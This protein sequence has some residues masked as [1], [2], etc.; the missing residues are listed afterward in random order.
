MELVVVTCPT[1]FEAEGMLINDFFDAGLDLLHIRKPD[2]EP[3]HFLRL[4]S[5]IKPEFY[6]RLAI[7]QHH[8]L[9]K[10]FGLQRLHFTERQRKAQ[11]L[12]HLHELAAAGYRLSSSVHQL[13]TFAGLEELSYVF[14]GPVFDSISKLGYE[15][16]LEEGFILPPHP[17]KVFAIGGAQADRFKEIN[18]M[19][20][21]GV[22]VLGSLWYQGIPPLR[23]LK[24][25]MDEIKS[26]NNGD[27]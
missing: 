24:I 13:D 8:D 17:L 2:Q 12:E 5:T 11:C 10:E 20:F 14:F 3:V 27:R 25:M 4:M 18:K 23:G 15:S 1:Y 9:A 26:L 7:H 6:P 21:D 19:N 16:K 22:A